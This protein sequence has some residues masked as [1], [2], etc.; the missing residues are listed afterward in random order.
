[1]TK[2]VIQV[3]EFLFIYCYFNSSVSSAL[4]AAAAITWKDLLEPFFYKA[5]ESRKAAIN[6]LCGRL[7]SKVLHTEMK[8]G[9]RSE[10]I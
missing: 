1:M 10:G 7:G 6:R 8:V 2:L 3:L 9:V 4:N 5:T